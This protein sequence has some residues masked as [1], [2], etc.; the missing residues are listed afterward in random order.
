[1]TQPGSRRSCYDRAMSELCPVRVERVRR[2][3]SQQQLGKRSGLTQQQIA[4][5]E[6]GKV[7]D[8]KLTTI[9]ALCQ[10]LGMSMVGFI[11]SWLKWRELLETV[12]PQAVAQKL[13]AERKQ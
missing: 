7:T 2:G 10:A 11:H 4:L 13:L 8:P 6:Q 3:W 12:S 1:M 9:V 5:L